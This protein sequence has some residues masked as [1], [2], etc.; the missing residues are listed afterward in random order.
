M[1]RKILGLIGIAF[2]GVMLASCDDS[3]ASVP[4]TS[5]VDGGET[6][7]SNAKEDINGSYK[8]VSFVENPD[9]DEKKDLENVIGSVWTFKEDGTYEWR[10]GNNIYASGTYNINESKYKSSYGDNNEIECGFN[11]DEDNFIIEIPYGTNSGMTV[12]FHAR[13]EKI[14]EVNI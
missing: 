8:I 12:F 11:I 2:I 6:T 10:V 3:N 14:E 1:K 13:L 5:V 4:A 9:G 7:P